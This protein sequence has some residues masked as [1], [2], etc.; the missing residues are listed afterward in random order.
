MIAMHADATRSMVTVEH[1]LTG[2]ARRALRSP[3]F[4]WSI[5]PA[6]AAWLALLR[7]SGNDGAFAL[8]F[9]PRS[10]FLDGFAASLAAGFATIDPMRWAVVWGLMIAAMMFPLL[11]PMV[12][13]VAVRSFAARRDRSIGLF[14]AGYALTWLAAA[15]LASV[16][17]MIAH[18]GLSSLGLASSSGLIGCGLAALWQVSSAKGR[19]VNRCHGT[20]AL[21]PFGWAADRDAMRFGLLHG[22]RCVR[23]CLATMVLPLAGGHGVGA[24][25][26]VFV[27]LL[28]ERARQFPQYALS[29]MALLLL[30]LTTLV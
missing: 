8:C 22:S 19:A 30:G 25:A 23:A 16:A 26:V 7:L 1:V 17:L 2:A 4:R 27:L 3:T 21:R 6:L 28:A 9:A 5:L 18:A 14:V 12:G 29:A 10:T 15:T 11:V 24:M 13:H 20:V